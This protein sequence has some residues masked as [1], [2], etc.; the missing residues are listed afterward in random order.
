MIVE[1]GDSAVEEI[2]KQLLY[3]FPDSEFD[4]KEFRGNMMYSSVCKKLANW[5]V[6][7]CLKE[8]GYSERVINTENGEK[9]TM[10]CKEVVHVIQKKLALIQKMEICSFGSVQRKGGRR[11]YMDGSVRQ[12][13]QGSRG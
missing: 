10:Y 8:A 5:D 13:L 4:I 1:V 6:G 7:E 11:L 2:A 9:F 12:F 3:A